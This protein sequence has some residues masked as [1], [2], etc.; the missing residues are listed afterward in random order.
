MTDFTLRPIEPGDGPAIDELIRNE[1]LSTRLSI[2]THYQVDPY[3]GLLAQHPT[4]FGVAATAPGTD[5]L[6]GVA[7]A[8]TD[9]LRVG[10][11]TFPG[12]Y[13]ENLKVHH[14]FRRQGLGRRMAE[15]RIA[16]ADR[17]FGGDGIIVTAVEVSNA[18]SLA[19]A[20][21][22]ATQIVGP[23]RDVIATTRTK[24]P[25]R[26][27]LTIRPLE[28]RET[29]AVVDGLNAFNES[30]ELYPPQ[31]AATLAGHHAQTAIGT[32]IRQYRVAVA[33]RGTIVAGASVTERFR[34]M[35]DH[36]E[37][38]PKPLELLARVTRVFPPDHVIRLV[39]I[40]LA[41]HAPGRVDA[42]RH[43]WEAIRY[44]WRDVATHVASETDPRG[45]L[46]EAFHVGFSVVPKVELMIP[47]R[48]PVPL[49]PD[50]V[51]YHWR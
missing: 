26:A 17:R 5:G 15:W 25:P 48:S 22:W 8:F 4:T 42:A 18:A 16:E 29:E 30:V 23:L 50:R 10:G 37:R 38:I 19:T 31:T 40:T 9:D 1:A 39:E 35:T 36:V 33:P 28:E 44:E 3:A 13:L 46:F 11:R 7:T 21:S 47:V 20:R 49:D 24:A 41:W 43:L 45:S 12:A 34:L 14:A 51:V 6:V 32:P 27:D 2:A